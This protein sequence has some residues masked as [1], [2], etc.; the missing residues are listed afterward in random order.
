MQR[1]KNL[2][3]DEKGL[4]PNTVALAYGVLGH[5]A[6]LWLL[7]QSS[8][9]LV[10]AGVALTAHT[11]V[12]CAYLV[13][14]AA[15]MTLFKAKAVNERA[16]EVLLWIVGA[17]YASFKRVRHMHLRHH[18]DRADVSCFDYQA[19]LA[20]QPRWMQKLVYALEWAYVPAVELTMHYQ[21]ILRP[22][23]VER[24]KE[25]RKR[26]VVVA[27]SRAAFFVVLFMVS[28]I[29]L[30]GYAVAYLI[31][32]QALFLADAFAHTYDA[33]FVD[34]DTDPVPPNDRDRAYDVKHTYSNL[35]STRF[36]RLNLLNL[37]FGYHTAHH[38]KA[39]VAWHDLP[40]FHKQLYGGA[41][42]ELEHEQVLPYI[43]LL[44]TLHRNRLKR[45]FVG[46][47]GD[48]GDGPNRGDSFIGAHGV[49]FLTIV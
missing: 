43:E 36:P 20:K 6:G 14:E 26:V 28:P 37:N 23:F 21:V 9:L 13:H 41:K 19:F 8:W 30:L 42:H 15:H 16:G 11:L 3:R 2:W 24:L 25:H 17:A 18:Q 1:Y 38:E 48:V 44:R 22:F 35:V 32:I 27:F 4:V 29:A 49:S 31:M 10:V 45:I 39:S 40:E 46:D 33:F 34:N 7:V 5:I 47:Y 12:I